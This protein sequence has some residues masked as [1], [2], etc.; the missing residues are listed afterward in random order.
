S[1]QASIPFYAGKIEGVQK[2]WHE[3]GR[4]QAEETY[5]HSLKNG[6]SV[7]WR[8]DGGLDMRLN[9]LDDKLDGTQIWFHPDGGKA[10]EINLSRGVPHGSWREWDE[11]GK[12][13]IDD[14]YDNGEL[15]RKNQP[16]PASPPAAASP[17]A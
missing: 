12:S 17:E 8:P 9:Y 6:P 10:R 15:K 2:T 3:N 14:E 5:R 11:T 7:F 1:I 4:I 13:L 16:P